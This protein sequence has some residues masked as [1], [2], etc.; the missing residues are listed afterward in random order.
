MAHRFGARL[1]AEQ[2]RAE[3]LATGARPRRMVLTGVDSLT[4]SERRVAEFAVQGLSNRQIAQALFISLRTVEAHLARIYR[5]LDVSSRRDLNDA[6]SG[7]S[8]AAL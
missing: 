7:R 2:A 6:L 1:L 8:P 3:L 5:K 4:A